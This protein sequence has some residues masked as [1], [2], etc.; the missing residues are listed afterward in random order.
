MR[1]A[2]VEAVGHPG[3]VLGRRPGTRHPCDRVTLTQ[4]EQRE[5]RMAGLDTHAA[6]PLEQGLGRP[7]AHDQLVGARQRTVEAAHAGRTRIGHLLVTQMPAHHRGGQQATDHERQHGQRGGCQRRPAES[8][9]EALRLGPGDRRL[10]RLQL[11]HQLQH[12]VDRRVHVLRSEVGQRH[13]LLADQQIAGMLDRS[14]CPAHGRRHLVD[15]L[16]LFV[17]E[18]GREVVTP[19]LRNARLRILDLRQ[20]HGRRQGAIARAL[21]GANHVDAIG[22]S[23]GAQLLQGHHAV[24]I[25]GVH[26]IHRLAQ[27]VQ[28]Q[29]A[30]CPQQ[31]RH[32]QQQGCQS[33]L[34]APPFHGADRA[35]V[36]RAGQAGW[37]GERRSQEATG[38]SRAS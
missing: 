37:C 28:G 36:A 7:L 24:A 9:L 22:L 18:V 32:R 6:Q 17:D 3:E 30:G 15:Q 26:R 8:R 31:Q 1:D 13:Q 21:D 34:K 11:A 16:L 19:L 25:D 23:H 20:R 29:H 4:H 10:H 33:R 2:Q 38:R 14:V 27:P 12:R 35:P 5:T